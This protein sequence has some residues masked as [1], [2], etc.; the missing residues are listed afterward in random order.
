MDGRGVPATG[1][2][3]GYKR[4]PG[5]VRQIAFPLLW[6]G[7]IL[8]DT[9]FTKTGQEPYCGFE[10]CYILIESGHETAMFSGRAVS[11]LGLLQL[12]AYV[13]T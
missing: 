10:H 13:S 2:E 9:H 3:L 11:V 7:S 6:R 4:A 12:G 5:K 8:C 1:R